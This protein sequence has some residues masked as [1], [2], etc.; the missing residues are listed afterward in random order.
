MKT[1]KE[2]AKHRKQT[3]LQS[4]PDEAMKTLGLKANMFSREAID[5][6]FQKMKR[7]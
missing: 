6:I 4:I 7:E 5:D 2:Q 3:K 1:L